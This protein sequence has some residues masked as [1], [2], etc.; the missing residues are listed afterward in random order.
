MRT[1]RENTIYEALVGN[2]SIKC[3]ANKEDL[4]ASFDDS[5]QLFVSHVERSLYTFFRVLILFMYIRNVCK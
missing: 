1:M 3:K 4:L 5:K 2:S